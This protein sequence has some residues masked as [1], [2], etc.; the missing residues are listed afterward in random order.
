MPYL[1]I[2]LDRNLFK[3][4][5]TLESRESSLTRFFQIVLLLD[6]GVTEFKRPTTGFMN[7]LGQA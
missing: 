3:L 7:N 1:S 6:L 5:T 4:G 2:A